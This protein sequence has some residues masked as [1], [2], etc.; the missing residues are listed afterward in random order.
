[1]HDVA[2]NN[3]S[4]PLRPPMHGASKNAVETL[5][6]NGSSQAALLPLC[7]THLKQSMPCPMNE[8]NN[9]IREK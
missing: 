5:L 8:G 9:L 6:W 3:P 7:D 4:R 1:M 2:G